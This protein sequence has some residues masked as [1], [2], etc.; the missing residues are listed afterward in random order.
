MGKRRGKKKKKRVKSEIER[1]T[2]HE[3]G[4]ETTTGRERRD[5][6]QEDSCSPAWNSLD[7]ESLADYAEN[8]AAG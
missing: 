1:C 7:E 4:P 3:S 6:G 8:A 2:G 5:S